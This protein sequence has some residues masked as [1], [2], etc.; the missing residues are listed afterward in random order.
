MRPTTS[1]VP[2]L[3]APGAGSVGAG[4]VGISANLYNQVPGA[5]LCPPL[6]VFAKSTGN[7][8]LSKVTIPSINSVVFDFDNI[9]VQGGGTGLG[10]MAEFFQ[11]FTLEPSTPEPASLSLLAIGGLALLRRK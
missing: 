10:I 8:L 11:T 3:W 4:S 5:P 2:P 1:R 6:V 7:Q 9:V